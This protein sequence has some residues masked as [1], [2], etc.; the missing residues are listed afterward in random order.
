MYDPC[1]CERPPPKWNCWEKDKGP[2]GACKNLTYNCKRQW[3]NAMPPNLWPY[4]LHQGNIILNEMLSPKE[5]THR[6]S[7]Q[8]FSGSMVDA[9]RK[10]FQSSQM[11]SIYARWCPSGHIH[12]KQKGRSKVGV[13]CEMYPHH[14]KNVALVLSL[15]TR[16]VSPQFNV[17]FDPSNFRTI[18]QWKWVSKCQWKAGLIKP[19]DE[20]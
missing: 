8:I 7:H 12:H 19:N 10:Y 17:R 15:E 20:N 5:A 2:L 14:N 1:Q 13:Y 11:L 4:M 9:Y 3:P 18:T 16:P 6:N